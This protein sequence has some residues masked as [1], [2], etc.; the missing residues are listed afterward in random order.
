MGSL[1]IEVGCPLQCHSLGITPITLDVSVTSLLT[2]GL[3][4]ESA[5][6][7]SEFTNSM[8]ILPFSMSCPIILCLNRIY[9]LF[10]L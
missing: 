3:V 5:K 6:F 2:S 9:Q 1:I 4:K 7:L 8:D 10:Q